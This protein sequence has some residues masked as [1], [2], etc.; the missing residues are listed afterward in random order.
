M[1][2]YLK[3]FENKKFLLTRDCVFRIIFLFADGG[4]AQL[5]RATGSYPVDRWFDPDT[6]YQ[7]GQVCAWPL[8]FIFCFFI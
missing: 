8:F 7:Q 2:V 5:A 6:R 4:L 3:V 1:H